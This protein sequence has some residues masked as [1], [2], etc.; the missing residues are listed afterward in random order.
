MLRLLLLL[1]PA[2][3]SVVPSSTSSSAGRLVF[4]FVDQQ[5]LENLAIR[6]NGHLVLSVINK[7][8]VYDLDPRAHHPLPKVLHQF[9]GVIERPR[10]SS[11]W[12]LGIGRAPNFRRR[13]DH[14]P[15]GP[16]I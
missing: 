5:Q 2:L 10:T 6:S 15:F 7:P 4:E 11:L 14:F 16:S 8:F 13:R 12:S 3:S 9:S 1:L